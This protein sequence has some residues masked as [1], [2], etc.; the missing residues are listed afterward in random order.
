MKS[1]LVIDTPNS[2]V[3]CPLSF[4]SQVYREYQCRGREYYRTISNYEWQCKQI[5]QDLRPH[6]CPL[7]PLPEYKD[8]DWLADDYEDGRV[9][10][11]NECIDY[12]VGENI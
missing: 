1:I 11:W 5:G 2:C 7:L 3:T 6:F 9:I 4:Y 10:G 12:I 8:I